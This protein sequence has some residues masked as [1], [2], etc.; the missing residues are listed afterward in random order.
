MRHKAKKRREGERETSRK[1][2]RGSDKRICHN[3]D[4]WVQFENN[5]NQKRDKKR[6]TK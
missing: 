3:L 2:Q 5:N 4:I 6:E 1:L